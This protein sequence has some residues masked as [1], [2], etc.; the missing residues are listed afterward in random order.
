[1]RHLACILILPLSL[2]PLPLVAQT[3]WEY[4]SG[5]NVAWYDDASMS[6]PHPANEAAMR[7][8]IRQ[9]T[10]DNVPGTSNT[11]WRHMRAESK[12]DTMLIAPP[13]MDNRSDLTGVRQNSDYPVGTA[14]VIVAQDHSVPGST[15]WI[16]FDDGTNALNVEVHVIGPNEPFPPKPQSGKVS[17]GAIPEPATETGIE[18]ATVTVGDTMDRNHDFYPNPDRLDV[19]PATDHYSLVGGGAVSFTVYPNPFNPVA[20]ITFTLPTDEHVHIE[21]YN[22]VGQRIGTLVDLNL[23]AGKHHVPFDVSM[24][25]LPSGTYLANI[26]AG[27]Y[28]GVKRITLL[29]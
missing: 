17:F 11:L 20:N 28:R 4:R 16:R 7:A 5:P 1:M 13:G 6:F 15:G 8:V 19:G 29:K 14:Y 26:V 12:A 21:I 3:T 24:F 22:I 18:T 27:P 25:N 2:L 9:G 23:A 10:H